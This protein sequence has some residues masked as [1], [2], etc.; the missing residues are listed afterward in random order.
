MKDHFPTKEIPCKHITVKNLLTIAKRAAVSK[1]LTSATFPKRN[2][3][4]L[5]SNSVQMLSKSW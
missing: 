5:L 1:K 3:L 4:V 2:M